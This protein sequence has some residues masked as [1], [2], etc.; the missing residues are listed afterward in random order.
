MRMHT[1]LEISSDTWLAP[2]KAS[3]PNT[4]ITMNNMQTKVIIGI[5]DIKGEGMGAVDSFILGVVLIVRKSSENCI[6]NLVSVY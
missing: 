2:D 6:Y 1:A 4:F 3:P 5:R